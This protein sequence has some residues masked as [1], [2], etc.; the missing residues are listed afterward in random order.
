MPRVDR[1]LAGRVE[2]L[3]AL[4]SCQGREGHGRKRCTVGGGADVADAAGRLAGRAECGGDDADRVDAGGLAL[5]VGGADGGVPLN[6]LNRAHAGS[7]GAQHVGNGLVALEV[8]E[9]VVPVIRRALLTRNQPQLAGGGGGLRLAKRGRFDGGAEAG[10][11]GRLNARGDTLGEAVGQPKAAAARADNLLVGHH[12]A[13]YKSGQFVVPAELALALGVQVHQ[14]APAAGDTEQV[15]RDLLDTRGELAVV[16]NA[17]DRDAGKAAVGISRRVGHR[18]ANQHA[19]TG[20]DG[21]RSHCGELRAGVH[22]GGDLDSGGLQ[23]RGHGVSAVIGGADDHALP[24]SDGVAVE[25]AADG[26]GEHD[27]GAVV[28]L[29]HQRAFVGAGGEHHLAGTDVPNTLPGYP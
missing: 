11:P 15:T 21:G 8:H 3:A 20:F 29:E 12:G 27:A 5:V 16:V 9:V 2:Q 6:V 13:R 25:V 4:A 26:R 22:D 7:G 19:R 1:G 18:A 23:V 24:C 28:V 17:A 10:S 14:R